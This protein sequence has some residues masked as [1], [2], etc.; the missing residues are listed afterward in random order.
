M[1]PEFVVKYIL[2]L[3]PYAKAFVCLAILMLVAV[4]SV[5]LIKSQ[6]IISYYIVLVAAAILSIALLFIR[7]K[8]EITIK[9]EKEIDA[10][11]APVKE[12]QE[13]ITSVPELATESQGGEE[14][15]KKQTEPVRKPAKEIGRKDV[16]SK[17]THDEKAFIAPYI[18]KDITSQ[19]VDVMGGVYQSLFK[20]KILDPP[21]SVGYLTRRDV[22]IQDWAK[23]YLVANP[24][25]LKGYEEVAPKEVP[26]WW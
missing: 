16:L 6:G 15:T 11:N 4:F 17:L 23:E 20:K 7:P 12:T 10:R 24:E 22:L 8:T 18:F 21:P 26:W 2:T 3:P 9:S 14:S 19:N 25:L 5:P 13:K 1:V